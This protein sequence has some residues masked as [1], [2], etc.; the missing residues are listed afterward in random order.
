MGKFDCP[1]DES[2]EKLSKTVWFCG[3]LGGVFWR[4]RSLYRVVALRK[5]TSQAVAVI[6]GKH[7]ATGATT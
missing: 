4:A 5:S 7:R 1:I 3:R 6:I 2:L